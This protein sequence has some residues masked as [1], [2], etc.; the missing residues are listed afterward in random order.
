MWTEDKVFF[1]IKDLLKHLTVNN[2]THY[3]V[4]KVGLRLRELGSERVYWKIAGKGMHVW[5][6]PQSHF[7]TD[8]SREIELPPNPKQERD[9][10]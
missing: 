3:S 10:M 6:F 9:V 5:F 8:E 7:G 2:F 4:N 1:Q